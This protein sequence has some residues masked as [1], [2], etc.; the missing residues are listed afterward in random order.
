MVTRMDDR[1]NAMDWEG[2]GHNVECGGLTKRI[3]KNG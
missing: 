3:S 2:P 1:V